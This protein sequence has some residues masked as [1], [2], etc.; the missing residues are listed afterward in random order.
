MS[1]PTIVGAHQVSASDMR[2]IA[3]LAAALPRRL[4]L[5]GLGQSLVIVCAVHPIT[6]H[7]SLRARV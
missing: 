7:S 3:T 1:A 2:G 4:K 5:G 6:P